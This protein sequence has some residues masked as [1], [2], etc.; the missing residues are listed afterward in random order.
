[1]SLFVFIK[2]NEKLV[3]LQQNYSELIQIRELNLLVLCTNTAPTQKKYTC[4]KNI[5]LINKFN[6]LRVCLYSPTKQL[7]TGMGSECAC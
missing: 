4:C 5:N 6:L 7:K 1:M 2:K 3:Q